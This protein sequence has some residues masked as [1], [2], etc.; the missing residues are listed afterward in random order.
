MIKTAK[1]P[2]NYKSKDEM[3]ILMS[4]GVLLNV[5]KTWFSLN[6]KG[7]RCEMIS[8]GECLG[9]GVQSFRFSSR[10][11][12]RFAVD[13]YSIYTENDFKKILHVGTQFLSPGIT[14]TVNLV[15]KFSREGKRR[16]EP[17]FLKYRLQGERE[18]SISYLAYDREDGWWACDLYQFTYNYRI[19]HF[20]I[21][22]EGYDNGDSL[23]VEG[24]EFQPLV[25][26][27]H[28]D[29][30]Q[31]IS[32][33][34]SDS[35]WEEKLPADYEDIMERSENSL[36]WTAKEEAYSIIRKGFFISWFSLD[37]NG[38]KCH[39]LSAALIWH[40]EKKCYHLNQDLE[41]QFSGGIIA[42][43]FFIKTNVQS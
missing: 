26:V 17:I 14:Y 41:K 4:K 1:P 39:M 21:L 9:S 33:T 23:K 5:G 31:L 24:I 10:Y 29:E 2:L 34:D 18:S 19:V 3:M 43:F 38:K 42:I 12:S 30:K 11:N 35:N 32:D 6:K 37:K 13:T 7:E 25:N 22:F 15:F 40:W 16:R 27:E 20:Q 36:Q 28:V 8:I